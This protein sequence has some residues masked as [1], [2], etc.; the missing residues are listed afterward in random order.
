MHVHVSDCD[1]PILGNNC[2]SSIYT[3]HHVTRDRSSSPDRP[4]VRWSRA[5]LCWLSRGEGIP[6]AFGSWSA[7]VWSL[8][9]VVTQCLCCGSASLL[10][11][12]GS[13]TKSESDSSERQPAPWLLCSSLQTGYCEKHNSEP[14]TSDLLQLENPDPEFQGDVKHQDKSVVLPCAQI[15]ARLCSG[16][17][18]KELSASAGQCKLNI[19]PAFLLP[20]PLSAPS[21]GVCSQEL[22]LPQLSNTPVLP[23]TLHELTQLSSTLHSQNW[24]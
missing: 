2:G 15:R 6:S 19:R 11:E 8:E 21:T 13:W 12:L 18:T 3:P 7:G 9:H 16:K 5:R 24:N 10:A 4:V 17:E 22:L 20:V 23:R 14:K 1:F